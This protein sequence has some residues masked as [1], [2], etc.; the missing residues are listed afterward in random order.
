M[1]G[2]LTA[3]M[4]SL[5]NSCWLFFYRYFEAT[6]QPCFIVNDEIFKWITWLYNIDV[7]PSLNPE[8]LM[9]SVFK[10][11]KNTSDSLWTFFYESFNFLVIQLFKFRS[12]VE[13]PKN[14]YQWGL[15]QKP[16]FRSP[17]RQQKT[18]ICVVKRQ[19][20]L[21]F[22]FHFQQMFWI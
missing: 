22:T 13:F 14:L 10:L 8:N 2:F 4:V 6:V 7:Y 3:G 18:Q 16:S 5:L 19:L 21:A 20:V 1:S 12:Q 15:H 9:R 17:I 11:Y